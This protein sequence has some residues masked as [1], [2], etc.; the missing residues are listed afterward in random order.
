MVK[1]TAVVQ[2]LI[3][4]EDECVPCHWVVICC[5]SRNNRHIFY[6][7]DRSIIRVDVSRPKRCMK[8]DE[9]FTQTTCVGIR[10]ALI[11]S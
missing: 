11:V 4:N 5:R 2:R 10:V 9:V 3:E 6:W 7:L 8:D 1:L